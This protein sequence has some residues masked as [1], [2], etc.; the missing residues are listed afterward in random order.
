M[1][2]RNRGADSRFVFL[3]LMLA[4]AAHSIE[5]CVTKLYEVFPPA[6]LVS[7]LVSSNPAVGFAVANTVL[8]AFGI[9]CWAV[10]VRSGWRAARGLMWFWTL[11]ELINGSMHSIMAVS[12]GGY[13]PG[14]ATAPL[15]LLFA[16]WLA[17]LQLKGPSQGV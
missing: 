1:E 12:R 7:G 2:I 15:L 5:E 13:F 8:V 17:A 9:W 10:P 4:Q 16:V 3:C 14:A 11:L 6:R